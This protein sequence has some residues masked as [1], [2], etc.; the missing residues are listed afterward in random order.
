[1]ENIFRAAEESAAF[2]A[3]TAPVN[4]TKNNTIATVKERTMRHLL[5]FTAAVVNFKRKPLSNC[6]AS[7]KQ[8]RA[9]TANYSRGETVSARDG[10]VSGG[11]EMKYGC[12]G[13]RCT[14][15]RHNKV[16]APF[17]GKRIHSMDSLE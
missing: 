15:G 5:W 16:M 1:L 3:H 8:G 14:E 11:W 12:A 4:S 2:T 9:F 7:S 13:S 6:M 10:K 17:G